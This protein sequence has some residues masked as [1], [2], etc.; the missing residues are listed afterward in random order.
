MTGTILAYGYCR[1]SS[2]LAQ[3]GASRV[4]I[5]WDRKRR[6]RADL[7]NDLRPG[8]VVRVLF[9]RDLG[10]APIPDLQWIA[11]IEAKGARVEECRPEKRPAR[12][13]RPPKLSLDAEADA[14]LRAVWLDPG[15]SLAD[16]MQA[17]RDI[18]GHDITRQALYRRFGTPDNP[19]PTR[20]RNYA[21]QRHHARRNVLRR[22]G[23]EPSSS[24]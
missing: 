22:E 19:K 15:R 24:S 16:R 18:L 12:M 14:R 5:D 2:D 10:G 6:D 20:E 4:Y 21:V 23:R 7:L 9:I 8:D 1:T 17:A 13:G 3:L 11:R